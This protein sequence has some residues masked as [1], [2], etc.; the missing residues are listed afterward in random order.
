[1]IR[2]AL[3]AA[4]LACATA[5]AFAQTSPWTHEDITFPETAGW[6][7]GKIEEDDGTGKK[8][9]SM[10]IT[11]CGQEFPALTAGI[12]FRGAEAQ[13]IPSFTLNASASSAGDQGKATVDGIFKQKS[14]TCVRQTFAIDNNPVRNLPAFQVNATYLCPGLGGI[15]QFHN[16]TAYAQRKNG[17]LWIVAFDADHAAL[18]PDE[19]VLIRGAVTAITTR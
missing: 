15:F 2:T 16:V 12:G 4:A 7:P 5:P 19:E 13:D 10:H 14:E 17:D 1:M 3:A 18:T 9:Q 6:C 8:T 11:A